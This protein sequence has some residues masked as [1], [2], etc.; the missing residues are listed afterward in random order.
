MCPWPLTLTLTPRD[1]YP[2]WRNHIPVRVCRLTHTAT[3]IPPRAAPEITAFLPQSV[4]HPLTPL[5]SSWPW[6]RVVMATVSLSGARIDQCSHGHL[7]GVCVWGGGGGGGTSY[8]THLI[9]TPTVMINTLTLSPG[10]GCHGDMPSVIRGGLVSL[11]FG[12]RMCISGTLVYW[13]I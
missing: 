5:F 7:G 2:Q 12:V 6:L 3:L 10:R 11:W 1:P 4:S 8:Y 13:L 9:T